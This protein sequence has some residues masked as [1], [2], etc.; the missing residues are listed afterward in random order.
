MNNPENYVLKPQREGGGN[1]LY[2]DELKKHLESIKESE[3]RNAFI[4]MEKI[5]PPIQSNYLIKVGEEL[6]MQ[7]FISEL[8]IFG[9]V[10]G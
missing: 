4:L 6:K 9:I 10:M 5:C 2:S 8:G 1:N 3:E 7:D